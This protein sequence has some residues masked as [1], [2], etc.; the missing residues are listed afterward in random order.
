MTT[1]VA[2][3][4]SPQETTPTAA[5]LAHAAEWLQQALI[6][7]VGHALAEQPQVTTRTRLMAGVAFVLCHY[8]ALPTLERQIIAEVADEDDG[9]DFGH[10]A[11]IAR[12][13]IDELT[14][15]LLQLGA[16]AVR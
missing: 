6:H 5:A 13:V 12:R 2:T 3:E 1:L 14:G 15:R 9:S 10:D 11:R 7:D 8:R 16:E 4:T